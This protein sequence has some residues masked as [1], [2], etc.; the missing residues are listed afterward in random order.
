MPSPQQRYLFVPGLLDSLSIWQ[1]DFG[2]APHSEVLVNAL[3]TRSIRKEAHTDWLQLAYNLLASGKPEKHYSHALNCLQRDNPQAFPL[4]A[5][6]AV[7][8]ASPV[9]LEAGMSDILVNPCV[10][11]DLTADENSQ[12]LEVLN[13]H[14]SQD[15]WQFVVSA[16]GRWY[17]ILPEAHKPRQTLPL[18]QALGSSLRDMQESI[19]SVQWSK[20]LNELQM[21]LHSSTVN[22]RRE[23]QRQRPVSSFWL[24]D[25]TSSS[26]P[27]TQYLPGSIAGGGFDGQSL[28]QWAGVKWSPLQE[29]DTDTGMIIYTDLASV[30]KQNNLALWQDKLNEFEQFLAPFLEN[31]RINTIIHSCNGVSWE[32]RKGLPGMLYKRM[33]FLQ[34]HSLLD[35]LH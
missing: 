8:C 4:Q 34:K 5:N 14:F 19:V 3:S 17:L 26:T 16:A 24:W 11:D 7:L 35:F 30:A 2:F 32:P 28:A 18:H 9:E 15:G 23:T 1:R 10:I 25:I 33:P 6:D 31:N 29:A 13:A 22:Q 21:L 12:L 27:A 20:Q